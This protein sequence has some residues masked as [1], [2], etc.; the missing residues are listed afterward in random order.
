MRNAGTRRI[1]IDSVFVGERFNLGVLLKVLRRDILNV[2]IDCEHWLR[3]IRDRG[4]ADLL[5]LWNYGARVVMRHHM[6]RTNGNE[7]SGTDHG[8]RGE[9]I[10]VSC[11]NLLNKRQ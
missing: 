5:E 3:R 8:S 10:R 11:G 6:A 2:V 7:I 1:K 4:G 9:S